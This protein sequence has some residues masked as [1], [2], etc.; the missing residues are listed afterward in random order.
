MVRAKPE[1]GPLWPMQHPFP[2]LPHPPTERDASLLPGA[3]RHE[4]GALWYWL[5]ASSSAMVAALDT[6]NPQTYYYENN[7]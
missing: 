5:L 2:G 7:P 4:S 6:P 1:T 3:F